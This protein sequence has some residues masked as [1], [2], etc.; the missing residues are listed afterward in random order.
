[1]ARFGRRTSAVAP[2]ATGT[3]TDPA[4]SDSIS[5]VPPP[6]S[7]APPAGAPADGEPGPRAA[8][9]FPSSRSCASDGGSRRRPLGSRRL[10]E[11]VGGAAPRHSAAAN[12]AG[13]T[14]A[15][16]RP[17]RRLDAASATGSRR[18]PVLR[19]DCRATRLPPVAASA[20]SPSPVAPPSPSTPGA[21]SPR[22]SRS[23]APVRR[24]DAVSATGTRRRPVL[25]RD[26]RTVR[27]PP[28]ATGAPLPSP[29]APPSPSAPGAPS[30]QSLRS[31]APVRRLNAAGATFGNGR[32]ETACATPGLPRGVAPPSS[33][34]C[35]PPVPR[36]APV[37]WITR[38][39][40]YQGSPT[41]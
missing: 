40:L 29:A 2:A 16:R 19:R 39:S 26:C 21:P 6:S 32:E 38:G 24:L 30:P 28:V 13:A 20:P 37:C 14:G 15:R 9:P 11:A 36:G 10:P 34:R 12:A 5:C 25:R 17:V 1:M 4:A 35:A 7:P 3:A 22:S 18:R 27:L 23:D 8:V 33:G 31:D 41:T